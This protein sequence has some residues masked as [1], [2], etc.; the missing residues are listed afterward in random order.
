MLALGARF[1]KHYKSIRISIN[2][3]RGKLQFPNLQH[4]VYTIWMYVCRMYLYISTHRRGMRKMRT[5]SEYNAIVVYR[6]WVL[7]IRFTTWRWYAISREV[8]QLVAICFPCG[9][10]QQHAFD[11]RR[12]ND[13]ETDKQWVLCFACAYIQTGRGSQSNATFPLYIQT[14]LSVLKDLLASTN[15]IYAVRAS[16]YWNSNISKPSMAW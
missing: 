15:W 9:N 1:Y 11:F 6:C 14:S 8:Q 16:W 10:V 7:A 5:Q 12:W 13:G 2:I 3:I 4:S